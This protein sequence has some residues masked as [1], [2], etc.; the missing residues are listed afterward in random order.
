[1][2]EKQGTVQKMHHAG[3]HCPLC[4]YQ[5]RSAFSVTC[6]SEQGLSLYVVCVMPVLYLCALVLPELAKVAERALPPQTE[7]VC[8]M[9]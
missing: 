8:I 7:Q 1:M 4:G 9:L 5:Q 6:S 2:K 3:M